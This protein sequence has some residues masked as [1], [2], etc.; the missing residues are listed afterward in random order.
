MKK[1]YGYT[2]LQLMMTI[3]IVVILT[4]ISHSFYKSHIIRQKRTVAEEQLEKL[5]SM[6]NEY[7]AFYGTY[8]TVNLERAGFTAKP[9]GYRYVLKDVT[10]DSYL[11]MAVPRGFQKRDTNCG[12]LTLNSLGE[13]GITG[14]GS[15]NACWD[16][17][18][19]DDDSNA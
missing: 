1:I 14:P 5:S 17:D 18:L 2:T 11:A 10:A 4:A 9:N 7:H 19:T 3:S 8:A 6:L 13:K 16:S 15:I 12:T